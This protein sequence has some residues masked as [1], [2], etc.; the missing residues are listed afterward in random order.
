MNDSVRDSTTLSLPSSDESAAHVPTL[1]RALGLFT[2]VALV[3]GSVIG[4]GIFA[5][6]GTIAGSGLS[7]PTILSVWML[8]GALCVLG[9]LCFAE[10]AAML[11]R[12]GGPY[13]YLREAFGRPTAFLFGWTEV[14]LARPA[15]CGALAMMFA[16]AT[17]A[18]AGGTEDVWP[19]IGV[20][21]TL[22][23]GLAWIN[24]VGV[25]WGGRVQNVTTLIK[26]GGVAAVA[27]LPFALLP[28]NS[29][30]ITWSNYGSRLAADQTP[31]EPFLAQYA[32]VL[33][34]VMWAYDGWHHVT[35]IAEEIRD[36]Q[37]NVPRALFIGIGII[38]SLYLSANLAYYGVLSM[39]ELAK[40]GQDGAFAAAVRLLGSGG[41]AALTAVIMCSTL[42]AINSN[43]LFSPRVAYAMGRD[44]VFFAALGRVHAN[45]R[46]PSV[47]IVVQGLMS[48][49]LVVAAGLLKLA[50]TDV[51]RDT[52][53]DSRLARMVAT[54]QDDSIFTL[55]TNFVIFA[56]S[57]FYVLC[58]AAVIVLRW[59][60]PD[61]PRPYRTFGY[62]YTPLAFLV[63][64]GWF[65]WAIYVERPFE[66]QVGLLLIA[67]GLPVFF[68]FRRKN[69]G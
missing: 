16:G 21:L 45:Y 24:V 42:G 57:I 30:A 18:A 27:I 51:D 12:A 52:I 46:T 33:L 19:Q 60:Q 2:A 34:A 31:Q 67:L 49:A 39:T 23:G 28:W 14:L 37:R 7:F 38:I 48:M 69:S 58:V 68:V 47:A 41:G 17:F 54:I 66:A 43:L 61:A 20:A 11:P 63:V 8:G 10:L 32:V 36:P 22:I 4:S 9:G 29:E 6:P 62:P 1:L 15:S 55:L 13:V 25:V 5:K 3:V 53:D 64:Y 50:L 26:A 65:L 35:P 59:R 56:A 44:R 40:A